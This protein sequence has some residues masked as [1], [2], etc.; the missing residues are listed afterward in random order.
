[1]VATAALP[2]FC[3]L[4]SRGLEAVMT[5]HVATLVT[6]GWAA[7]NGRFRLEPYGLLRPLR[8]VRGKAS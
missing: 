6:L 1:M 3:R 5:D 8:A 4:H 2:A 7:V